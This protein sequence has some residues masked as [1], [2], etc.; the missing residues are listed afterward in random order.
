MQLR[1]PSPSHGVSD[2][3]DTGLF[4]HRTYPD[5]IRAT[6]MEKMPKE[7]F[8][9]SPWLRAQLGPVMGH[10][11]AVTWSCLVWVRFFGAWR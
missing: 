4:G 3:F 5:F 6:H 11:A 1:F 2:D 9:D 8:E 10:L 7:F